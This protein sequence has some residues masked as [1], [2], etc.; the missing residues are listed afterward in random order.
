MMEAA[1]TSETSVKFYQTTQRY[2]PEDSHLQTHRRENFNSNKYCNN[3]LRSVMDHFT[4]KITPEILTNSRIVK[5]EDSAIVRQ[6]QRLDM[7]FR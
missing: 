7:A 1:S 6:S 4:D 5:P 2:N 3:S